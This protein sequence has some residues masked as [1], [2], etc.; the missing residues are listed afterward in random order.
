MTDNER[1]EMDLHS[2]VWG[3]EP[4]AFRA[5]MDACVSRVSQSAKSVSVLTDAERVLAGEN[6]VKA[7]KCVRDRTGM[8]LVESRDA[9][10]EEMPK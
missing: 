8:G 4:H 9:V 10:N 7:I 6:R 5:L 3:L 2:F 1:N